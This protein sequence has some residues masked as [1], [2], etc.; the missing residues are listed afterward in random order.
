VALEDMNSASNNFSTASG[1]PFAPITVDRHARSL[2]D[3]WMAARP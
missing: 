1:R 2:S 3:Q